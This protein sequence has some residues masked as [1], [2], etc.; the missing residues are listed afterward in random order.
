M[1]NDLLVVDDEVLTTKQLEYGLSSM[2]Y[3]VVGCA[4]SGKE[5]IEMAK[6][7]TPD[8]IL[9][10][11]VMPG[12]MDGIEASLIIKRELDIPIIFVTAHLDDEYIK[13]ASSVEP[14][15]YILKPFQLNGLKALIDLTFYICKIKKS[16]HKLQFNLRHNQLLE[17]ANDGIWILDKNGYTSFVNDRMAEILGYQVVDFLFTH[18]TD[19]IEEEDKVWMINKYKEIRAGKPSHLELCFKHKNGSLV[20]TFTSITPIM[21]Q[22]KYYNGSMSIIKDITGIKHREKIIE[23]KLIENNQII[24]NIPFAMMYVKNH[25][26]QWMNEKMMEITGY[27]YQDLEHLSLSE[28]FHLNNYCHLYHD[29]KVAVNKEVEFEANIKVKN[30]LKLYG[31]IYIRVLDCKELYQG[32]LWILKEVETEKQTEYEIE[33][34]KD[35]AL[36]YLNLLQVAVLICD[37]KRK[38]RLI[39]KKGCEILES[40]DNHLLNKD[41]FNCLIPLKYRAQYIQFFY[42]SIE[43]SIDDY[44]DYE[45]HNIITLQ[46]NP[47]VIG[48]YK[49]F[50]VKDNKVCA[51]IYTGVD[52]TQRVRMVQ[53]II[54]SEMHYRKIVDNQETLIC[55]CNTEGQLIYGN[56]AFLKFF[57]IP[58]AQLQSLMF[59]SLIPFEERQKSKKELSRLVD[60]NS[61]DKSLV[62][63]YFSN[64]KK[65]WI[66]W[67]FKS[68]I[69][70]KNEVKEILI[71]GQDITE[72][73]NSINDMKFTLDKYD[74]L[75]K[76][77]HHRV[78]NNLQII[79]SFIDLLSFRIHDKKTMELF[80]EAQL[81][82][83]TIAIIHTQL[84]QTGKFDKINIAETLKKQ[85]S[86]IST[87]YINKKIELNPLMEVEDIEITTDKAILF[88]FIFSELISNIYK[89]AF[90]AREKGKVEI[91]V[92][93]LDDHYIYISIH[94]NGKG[95][96]EEFSVDDSQSMGLKLIRDMV[97]RQLKGRFSI[98]NNYGTY[99]EIEFKL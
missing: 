56:Y 40:S 45:E 1:M 30:G 48:W 35:K 38:I 36:E 59:Y 19:F 74:L 85:F 94:D 87:T 58:K 32:S 97:T 53:S 12:E 79:S 31:K 65:R 25:R 33:T 83:N 68:I 90:D 10:D 70:Q 18:Y 60:N 4:N 14:Y 9:M 92:K 76:E 84:Y 95:L 67:S 69:G 62:K 63:T 43:Q 44:E 93:I 3:N 37:T 17:I 22:D 13:R 82:I 88:S 8:L 7:L 20:Y 98:I 61:D 11:I 6:K 23:Q 51:L 27:S 99:V 54:D 89:H 47:K 26:I 55:R 29:E 24:Q 52:I 73:K 71:I 77:V 72:M 21:D 28:L 75:L 34:E 50:L 96:P 2:G 64:K 91:K 66:K 5:S 86:I 49:S 42:Q 46:G 57:Q 81:K 41:Y 39:N 15:G 16:K 80:N 78:K